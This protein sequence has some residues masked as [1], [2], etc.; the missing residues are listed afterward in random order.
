MLKSPSFRSGFTGRAVQETLIGLGDA[1]DTHVA[2][3][4]TLIGLGDASDTHVASTVTVIQPTS[5][6]SPL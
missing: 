1:S 6:S 2:P 3:I 4:V 5:Q